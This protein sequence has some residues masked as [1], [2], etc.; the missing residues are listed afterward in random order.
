MSTNEFKRLLKICKINLTDVEVLSLFSFLDHD[1]SGSISF[2]EFL[3][4]V[5]VC[6][7]FLANSCQYS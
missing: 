3:L 4:S 6:F 1:G 7:V 2:D 5:T